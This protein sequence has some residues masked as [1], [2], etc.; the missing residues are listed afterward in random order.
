MKKKRK[1]LLLFFYTLIFFLIKI[2]FVGRLFAYSNKQNQTYV[3]T[4][5]IVLKHLISQNHPEKPERVFNLIKLLKN[6]NLGVLIREI[7]LEIKEAKWIKTIHSDFHINSLKNKFPIGERSS[8]VAVKGCI[9]GIDLIMRNECKNIFCAVRPPGHH[10][11]NTGKPEG[12]C[13]YNHIAISAK[14]VQKN[15]KL[16][17]VLIIDWDYHHGNSTELFFYDDPSVLFF[18]THDANAYPRTGSP[19]RKGYGEGKGYNVNIH[20]PCGTKDNEIMN[21]YLNIL[22][23]IANKFQPEFVLIS[24]GFDGKKDDPLGCFNITDKGF[25]KLT[26]IALKIAEKHCNGRLLSILEGG[27]NIDGT[28]KAAVTHIETLN[29]FNKIV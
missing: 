6:K 28:S 25:K 11:L 21:T 7:N 10:A 23:K 1:F 3:L 20:L 15:Y 5:N 4:H 17:K 16:R 14:Y 12:F 18:S 27:Y 24:A 9:Q 22:E 13:F 8:L 26:T 2:K 19:D 29:N